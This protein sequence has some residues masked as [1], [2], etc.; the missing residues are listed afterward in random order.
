MINLRPLTAE[1]IPNLPQIRPTYKASTM[2]TLER[3]GEGLDIGWRLVE[4]Q[5]ARPYD[6]GKLYDFNESVQEEIRGRLSRADDTFARVAEYN[7]RLVGIAEA[8]IHYWNNT[9][10]LWSLMIDLAFRGQGLGRRLW[11]RV[12]EFARDSDVRAIMIETQNTNVA[13][14]KF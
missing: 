13:A 10:F 4:Y 3:S 9:V 11:H 5:L 2:L 6:K 12:V 14:C 1:D 7:G 8:E